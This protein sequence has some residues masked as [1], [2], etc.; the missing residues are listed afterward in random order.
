MAA[1]PEALK[2][3]LTGGEVP[4][5]KNGYLACHNP[6][7]KLVGPAYK[8]VAANRV[9]GRQASSPNSCRMLGVSQ[10][11]GWHR[12]QLLAAS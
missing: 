12:K 11:M 4:A 9:S 10:F 5:D 2:V 3:L 1:N 7:E 6:A 8:E